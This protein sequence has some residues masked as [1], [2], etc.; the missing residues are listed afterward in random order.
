MARRRDSWLEMVRALGE[1]FFE[2]VRAEL[3][4][5]R[6]TVKAWGKSWGVALG[7]A[8]L[9]LFVLFW[10]LGLLAVAVVHGL[11]A[12]RGL[13]LWQAARSCWC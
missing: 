4:V 7:I 10:V 2:V 13:A 5:V 6:E 1:A 9:L 3:A 8:A 11:M 12:W